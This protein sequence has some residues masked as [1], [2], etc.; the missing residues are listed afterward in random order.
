MGMVIEAGRA[1]RLGTPDHI[2]AVVALLL[3]PDAD[4][5]TGSDLVVDGG[6]I[7]SVA[8]G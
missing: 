3:G 5:V 7:G 6:A 1:A 8:A 4:V 2:A